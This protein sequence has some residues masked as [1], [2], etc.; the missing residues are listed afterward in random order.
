VVVPDPVEVDEYYEDDDSMDL[1]A[2]PKID[3][4]SLGPSTNPGQQEFA[5]HEDVVA[6]AEAMGGEVEEEEEEEEPA[7]RRH[8]T[9][10]SLMVGLIRSALGVLMPSVNVAPGSV[11]ISPMGGSNQSKKSKQ[12]RGSV[13]KNS[14]R[15]SHSRG[16]R[17]STG[18]RFFSLRGRDSRDSVPHSPQPGAQGSAS[19]SVREAT[20]K[21]GLIAEHAA[22]GIAEEA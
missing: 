16:R 8:R 18:N 3:P 12:S 7:Q 6:F 15:N 17:A 9:G 19:G 21:K 20:L 10:L 5:A 11:S 13:S 22:R 14:H 1:P 4:A 2:R